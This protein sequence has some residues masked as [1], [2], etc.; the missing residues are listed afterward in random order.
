[1][2]AHRFAI[3]IA[4]ARAFGIGQ[5]ASDLEPFPR[6]TGNRQRQGST[7]IRAFRED[8]LPAARSLGPSSP[9]SSLAPLFR[10][11]SGAPLC[12]GTG[13]ETFGSWSGGCAVGV[14]KY[15][16]GAK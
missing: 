11:Q 14:T 13:A 8:P 15:T 9:L 2:G 3:S 1:M 6:T 5:P 10:A 4:K 16:G 7:V 12:V